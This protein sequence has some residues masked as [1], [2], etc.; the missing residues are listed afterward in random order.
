MKKKTS[1]NQNIENK[2]NIDL[3][4]IEAETNRIHREIEKSVD[5]ARCKRT[6]SDN[7]RAGGEQ[8]QQSINQIK[9][10]MDKTNNMNTGGNSFVLKRPATQMQTDR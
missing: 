3:D 9:V 5:S 10:L 2:E 4:E 8:R 7:T 6:T 1:R